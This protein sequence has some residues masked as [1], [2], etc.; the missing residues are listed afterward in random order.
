MSG[1][2]ELNPV[3]IAIFVGALVVFGALAL[4]TG[5]GTS[6]LLQ[7]RIGRVTG[8]VK[9][10]RNA[11][12][13]VSV[14]RRDFD[15]PDSGSRRLLARLMPGRAKI[16][17]RLARADKTTSPEAFGFICIV[18]GLV[19]SLGL[20][21][22]AKL[23]VAAALPVGVLLGI[24]IPWKVLQRMGNRR[25]MKFLEV[26]PDAI[27]LLV[28]SVR[29]GLPIGEAIAI[30]GRDLPDPVGT[31]F[32]RMANSMRL[33][34]TFEDAMWDVAIRLEIAEFNFFA[35]SLAV[36]RETG[37][38]IAETLSNLSSLIRARHM[39]KKKVKA[40]SAEARASAWIVGS[41]PFLIFLVL[42]LVNPDYVTKLFDDN[43]GIVILCMGLASQVIGVAIMAKMSK[44][45]I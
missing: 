21:V 25:A 37:G 38:N 14:R 22:G 40:L 23:P 43:R 18:V 30:G 44:F 45:E 11:P 17:A 32:A 27:D 34:R 13:P 31:E 16:A 12:P 9:G 4:A 42:I 15:L 33:G 36:Q 26:F 3:Y 8:V 41:L 2:A 5:S 35:T 28:R 7:R 10:P 1:L 24:F 19:I 20:V 29:C 39:M 6:A